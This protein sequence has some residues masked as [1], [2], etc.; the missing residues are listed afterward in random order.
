MSRIA[1]AQQMF[2]ATSDAIVDLNSKG[3]FQT[4]PPFTAVFKKI[5]FAIGATEFG[6]VSLS[7]PISY[8][9]VNVFTELDAPSLAPVAP[10]D[11][12]L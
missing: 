7:A 2:G 4:Q 3:G 11:S 10:A 5:G 1:H 9:V 12:T 6:T 8:R